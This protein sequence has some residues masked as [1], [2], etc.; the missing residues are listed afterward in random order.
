MKYL[1]LLQLAFLFFFTSTCFAQWNTYYDLISERDS[2]PHFIELSFITPQNGVA[3][4]FNHKAPA[5]GPQFNGGS[6]ISTSDSGKTWT[7]Q[8]ILDSMTFED[9]KYLS[10]TKVIAGAKSRYFDTTTTE[11]G[12]IAL[13]DDGGATW[14]ITYFPMRLGKLSILNDS[15][16]IVVAHAVLSAN[17]YSNYIISRDYGIS[18]TVLPSNFPNEEITDLLFMNDSIGFAS[19]R[20]G[21]LLKTVNQGI[22]W[23]SIPL[24]WS[25]RTSIENLS[26]PDSINLFFN[27]DE[28]SWQVV[29]HSPDLGVTWARIGQFQNVQ[30]LTKAEFITD[31]IGFYVGSYLIKTYDQ[32]ASWIYTSVKGTS[33]TPFTTCIQFFDENLIYLGGWN[34]FLRTNN[35]GDSTFLTGITSNTSIAPQYEVYPNPTKGIVNIQFVEGLDRVEVYDIAG[36][37]LEDFVDFDSAQSDKSTERVNKINLTNY[38][39]GIYFLK[40][41]IKS[42]KVY[43]KKVIKQ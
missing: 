39:N 43:S 40:L 16:I 30:S 14:S 36:K 12:A 31:S 9:V 22:S 8:V 6:L 3:A 1:K 25:G 32:G 24:P 20:T 35:G 13:S 33:Y 15:T 26:S 37:L 18:W 2:L 28:A 42:G 19:S 27:G 38:E 4:C 41:T 29:Y 11:Q 23:D 34:S 5:I 21:R 17:Q 7:T 10:A